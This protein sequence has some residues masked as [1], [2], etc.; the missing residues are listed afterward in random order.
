MM[1][2][3]NKNI[4][5][6]GLSALEE[7]INRV[8]IIVMLM[9][10]GACQCA[11]LVYTVEKIIGWLPTVSWPALIIFDLTC[12]I[13]LIVAVFLVKTGFKDGLVR[14]D[15]MKMGKIYI[16]VLEL[17]QFNFILHMIPAT[18]FWGFA[19]Y[20]VILSTFFLDYKLVTVVSLEIGLSVVAS[21]FIQGSIHLPAR[22]ENFMPNLLDRI[23]CV[24][25]CL[26]T[27]VLLTYLIH[28]FLV[29][30]KKN[31]MERN[32]QHVQR[33]LS[34]V[35]EISGNL[36]S[37]GQALSQ[38][39]ENESASA[40]ELSA[41]STQLLEGSNRLSAK[42]KESMENLSE[43]NKWETVVADNVEKVETTSKDL[44]DKSQEN[45]ILLNGLRSINGEVVSSMTATVDIAKKLSDAVA[46][47]GVTLNLIKEISSS[48]NLLALNASIEAA[49]AGDAGRGFA[50]VASEVGN[51]AGNTKQSLE[52]VE[53]VITRV[54]SN[55]N[56]IMLQVE[57]NSRKLE[58][59]NEQFNRV[60]KEMQEMTKLLNVS[61]DAISEMGDARKK[62]AEVIQN[63]V[64]INQ[65]IADNIQSEN[66]QFESINSMVENNAM[67]IT[68]MAGQV[69]N[70]NEMVE[71]L[72][73]LLE[74]T[75]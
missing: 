38:V 16:I 12:L 51:L 11:G 71:R 63:T 1:K 36:H 22:G 65:D 56:D 7:Y 70:I 42:T 74:I 75:D 37:A 41:T 19:F 9:I 32:N 64:T 23:I 45:T 44:L 58:Q 14:A 60:F 43:L 27:I 31:E 59:Q 48:T 61:F 68:E 35:Q 66:G 28:H 69:S 34:S 10:P 17:V 54:N 20:F 26:P 40:E 25:L 18:D 67:D 55:V 33:V 6:H 24:A 47:I 15:R 39:S 62:Q 8:Y 72:N 4:S 73:E 5:G 29:N 52:E 30:A 49:R 57:E 46:E 2:N 3:N 13:Y 21:W 53:S 50:V